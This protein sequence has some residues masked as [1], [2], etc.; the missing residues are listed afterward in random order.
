MR[1]GAQTIVF[2]VPESQRLTN[3]LFCKENAARLRSGAQTTVPAL[4]S[5]R[6]A[7]LAKLPIG[8]VWDKQNAFSQCRNA[9][10]LDSGRPK[11]VLNVQECALTRRMSIKM[12]SRHAGQRSRSMSVEPDTF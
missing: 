8:G 6:S 11:R 1:S 2:V 7:G 9:L 4:S 12:Q 3:R 5:I 10:S